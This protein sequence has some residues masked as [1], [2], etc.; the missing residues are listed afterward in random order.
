M[1]AERLNI[2]EWHRW[3]VKTGNMQLRCLWGDFTTYSLAELMEH[4]AARHG[5]VLA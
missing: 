4:F 2:P 3:M 1:V 5:R